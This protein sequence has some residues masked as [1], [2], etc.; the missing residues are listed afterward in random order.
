MGASVFEPDLG[1][2]DQTHMFSPSANTVINPCLA[3]F[4]RCSYNI[5]IRYGRRAPLPPWQ[6]G[7]IE[8]SLTRV[9]RVFT[10]HIPTWVVQL[11]V[12]FCLRLK[13]D[14]ISS[15]ARLNA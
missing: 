3:L 1:D 7:S 12:T 2:L 15:Q 4:Y 6:A 13:L 14:F 8:S 5:P 11:I 9:L 10:Y